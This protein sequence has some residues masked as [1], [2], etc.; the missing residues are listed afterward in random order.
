MAARAHDVAAQ[1]I[2]GQSAVLNFPNIADML[3]RPATSSRHDVQAA[4]AAM[5]NLDPAAVVQSSVCSEGSSSNPSELS[6]IVELPKIEDSLDSTTDEFMLYDWI[7]PMGL[8]GIEFYASFSNE[9][10]VQQSF[11]EDEFE[12]EMPIWD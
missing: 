7:E 12:F 11:I 10:I 5:I 9:L 6:E 8:G 4:A 1:S 2:K 3:P